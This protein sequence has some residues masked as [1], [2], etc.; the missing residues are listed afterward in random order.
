[1][2]MLLERVTGA[3]KDVNAPPGKIEQ[4]AEGSRHTQHDNDEYYVSGRQ[5]AGEPSTEHSFADSEAG[6]GARRD[7]PEDPATGES[8]NE[9]QQ[10][11]DLG[12][13]RHERVRD[14][15]KAAAN[16]HK[17]AA[18]Q[19]V[20]DE[21]ATR[22]EVQLSCF[23]LSLRCATG[24]QALNPRGQPWSQ[25]QRRHCEKSNRA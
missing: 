16:E 25:P 8:A 9:E 15:P 12:R 23:D 21:G 20:A 4:V 2:P 3:M 1:M 22:V 24:A 19:G 5:G 6:R 11:W 18:V 10:A 17:A 7:V 14:K 13:C